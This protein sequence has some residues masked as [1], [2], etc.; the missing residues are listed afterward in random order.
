MAG[1]IGTAG[2]R[3]YDEC[4][5]KMFPRQKCCT[6]IGIRHLCCC[7]LL[8]FYIIISL[9]CR[10]IFGMRTLSTSSRNVWAAILDSQSRGRLGRDI[11]FYQG[12]GRQAKGKRGEGEGK[13]KMRLFAFPC[14]P[15]P[16]PLL[17][18]SNMTA[19]QTIASL[20]R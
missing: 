13:G 12:G 9:Q 1:I 19:R 2:W 16:C 8:D 5:G 3:K 7:W 10:G 18:K 4:N 15:P 14:P 20:Q 17:S 11:N 6:C